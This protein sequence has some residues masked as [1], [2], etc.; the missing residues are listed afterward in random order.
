MSVWSKV[1]SVV[2]W[3]LRQAE[4]LGTMPSL[5]NTYDEAPS[6]G[7]THD[8]CW[9]LGCILPRVPAIIVRTG[10]QR[11]PVLQRAA[12]RRRPYAA[13]LSL[14]SG[15]RSPKDSKRSF[16]FAD[17]DPDEAGMPLEPR[18][19]LRPV[20]AGSLSGLPGC[21]L[22]LGRARRCLRRSLGESGATLRSPTGGARLGAHQRA[23]RWGKQHDD[24]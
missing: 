8:H 19:R 16:N 4:Q 10:L 15:L 21:L 12:L 5:T 1:K 22:Q 20:D 9:R 24:S 7:K 11:Q 23:I 6:M 13:R 2:Q 17:R 14:D 18:P 3:Q